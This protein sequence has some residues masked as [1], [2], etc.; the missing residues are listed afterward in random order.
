VNQN[1]TKRIW[2]FSDNPL[3]QLLDINKEDNLT[4]VLVYM[5]KN[6]MN[7]TKDFF[8]AMW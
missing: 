8:E 5:L 7:L 3:V 4:D 1:G 2:S 6:N